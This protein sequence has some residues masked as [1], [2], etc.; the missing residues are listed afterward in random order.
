MTYYYLLSILTKSPKICV[1]VIRYAVINVT[2]IDDF[3]KI[4]VSFVAGAGAFFLHLTVHERRQAT[5]TWLAYYDFKCVYVA[6]MQTY[7][8]SL[9][10]CTAIM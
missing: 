5:L 4:L 6:N 10:S 8:K 7:L 3:P 9:L 2:Q 1:C